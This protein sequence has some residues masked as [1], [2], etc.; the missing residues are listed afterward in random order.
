MSCEFLQSIFWEMDFKVVCLLE[1]GEIF[2]TI[3]Q[4]FENYYSLKKVGEIF[5]T[6]F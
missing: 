4:K 6:V 3:F 5:P 1:V 2:T